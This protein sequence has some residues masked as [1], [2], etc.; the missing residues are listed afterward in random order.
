M[1][2]DKNQEPNYTQD[3]NTMQIQGQIKLLLDDFA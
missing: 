2:L 3:W 1:I